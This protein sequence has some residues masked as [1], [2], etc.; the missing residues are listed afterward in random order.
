MALC[1]LGMVV[2][3]GWLA[4]F[5]PLVQILPGASAMRF[6]TAL[7]FSLCGISL[8]LLPRYCYRA[9]RVL[10]ALIA[11]FAVATASQDLLGID[12]SI[13]NLFFVDWSRI[14]PTPGGRMAINTAYCF[15]LTGI[16]LLSRSCRGAWRIQPFLE[17]VF[18]SLVFAIGIASTLGYFS[19]ME[20]AYGWG[21]SAGMAIHTALGFTLCG[22]VLIWL[23]VDHEKVWSRSP[24]WLP[25]PAAIMVLAIALVFWQALHQIAN[26]LNSNTLQNCTSKPSKGELRI[27]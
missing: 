7:L 6:N 10:G 19:G 15:V 22:A 12:L 13:D 9:V 4:H 18:G 17:G 27:S 20:A 5:A 8:F 16:T 23:A 21:G 14:G 3:S 1:L 24:V 25:I 11:T 2:M 26:A